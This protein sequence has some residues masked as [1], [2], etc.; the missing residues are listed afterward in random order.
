MQLSYPD[1]L[2]LFLCYLACY[3]FWLPDIKIF[4]F[5]FLKGI[6]YTN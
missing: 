6:F 1:N 3:K 4:D 2:Q 5:L